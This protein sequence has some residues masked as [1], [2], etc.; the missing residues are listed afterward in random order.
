MCFQR[1][2][3]RRFLFIKHPHLRSFTRA[4]APERRFYLQFT[5]DYCV[6]VMAKG[7]VIK[8]DLFQAHKK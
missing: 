7:F 6:F 3:S 8:N 2:K 4:R 5:I 1:Q